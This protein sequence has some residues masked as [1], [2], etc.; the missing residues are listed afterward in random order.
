MAQPLQVKNKGIAVEACLGLMTKAEAEACLG[1]TETKTL[2]LLAKAVDKRAEAEAEACLGLTT[3]AEVC[4]GRLDA[5]VM[6][7]KV[8]DQRSKSG[9]VT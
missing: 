3:R 1:L 2:V 9:T 6:A 7:R 4:L 8:F 5:N